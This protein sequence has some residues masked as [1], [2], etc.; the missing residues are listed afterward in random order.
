MKPASSPVE[1]SP[2]IRYPTL[3]GSIQISSP[4]ARE[5]HGLFSPVAPQSHGE[6]RESRDRAISPLYPESAIPG[7]TDNDINS[8]RWLIPASDSADQHE[9]SRSHR[10]SLEQDHHQHEYEREAERAQLNEDVDETAEQPRSIRPATESSSRSPDLIGRARSREVETDDEDTRPR[11]RSQSSNDKPVHNEVV[12]DESIVELSSRESQVP[13]TV[14]EQHNT[15]SPGTRPTRKR[16]AIPSS[17]ADLF[18]SSPATLDQPTPSPREPRRR[19]RRRTTTQARGSKTDPVIDLTVSS[20]PRQNLR[21]ASESSDLPHGPGWV[22]KTN[23]MAR[24]RPR[25]R[26]LVA[27]SESDGW[28]DL[29]S[30]PPR[31]IRTRSQ[32]PE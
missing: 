22:Q 21:G 30:S 18:P 27:R 13:S 26:S 9:L 1:N 17:N 7:S 14:P 31:R 6:S 32:R 19:G 15:R 25:T 12:E 24:S 28:E 10:T 5:A 20:S 3:T 16:H 23:E 2:T 4:D 29:G 8:S 11:S